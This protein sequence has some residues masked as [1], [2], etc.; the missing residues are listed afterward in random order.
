MKTLLAIGA[1]ALL[2][3]GAAWALTQPADAQ[4][5]SGASLKEFTQEAKDAD[6]TD[7]KVLIT[8]DDNQ[9]KAVI[10]DAAKATGRDLAEVKKVILLG[11][12]ENGTGLLALMSD[13]D[14]M[15]LAK[16]GP[17]D[18]LIMWLGA[19]VPEEHKS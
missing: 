14:C 18:V 19:I 6:A 9:A 10:E 12:K 1:A 13:D 5:C 11:S 3:V 16:Q 8:L 2:A 7:V 15:V 17:L 4:E